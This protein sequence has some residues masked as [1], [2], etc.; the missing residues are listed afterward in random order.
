VLKRILDIS[1]EPYHVSVRLDQLTLGPKRSASGGG[2][3]PCEDIGVVVVDHGEVT[4]THQALARLVEFGAAVVFCGANHL[5]AGL[6]LPLAGQTEVAHRT[7]IQA[8]AARPV[9]K[10][11]WKQIIR[12]KVR[13]QADN[14]PTDSAARRHLEELIPRVR[15]GDPDNIEA[16]AAR[17]YWSAWLD[18]APFRRETD[19]GDV[20]NGLLNYGYAVARAAV[21]RAL[22]AAGL[23]PAL[24]LHHR[25]RANPFCLADDL[26]EPLRPWVDVIVSH[27]LAAGV[28][29]VDRASKTALVE[30]LTRT[31]KCGDQ[32]GPLMVALHR[33]CASLVRC[34]AGADRTM[35]LPRLVTEPA[36]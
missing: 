7:L 5:P 26:L 12:T 19:G 29:S 2:S 24:G 34:L 16:Q 20:A 18:G 31:V 32:T 21:A 1:S 3:V 36:P 22:V 15:S 6:L 9:R 30:L 10:R 17:V 8:A 13:H 25:H 4:Y 28:Q 33:T 11:L 27:R 14:L 35:L 23:N